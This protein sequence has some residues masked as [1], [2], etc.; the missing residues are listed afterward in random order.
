[1][2]KYTSFFSTFYFC[3][4]YQNDDSLATSLHRGLRG[5]Y[6]L[7]LPPRSFIHTMHVWYLRR[8][9]FRSL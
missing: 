3:G 8:E 5:C 2:D 4:D 7:L 9:T 6:W 1:M